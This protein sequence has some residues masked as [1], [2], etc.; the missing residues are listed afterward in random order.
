MGTAWCLDGDR[1]PEGG[2]ACKGVRRKDEGIDEGEKLLDHLSFFDD[3]TSIV[4][5]KCY[6]WSIW[7]TY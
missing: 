3:V 4:K 7:R 6:D 1:M 2:K 5:F